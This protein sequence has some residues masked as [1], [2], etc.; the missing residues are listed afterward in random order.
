MYKWY[1]FLRSKG[2]GPIL[3]LDSAWY[4]SKYWTLEGE[5]PYGMKLK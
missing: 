5:W 4:N 3:S 2:Y 1:K